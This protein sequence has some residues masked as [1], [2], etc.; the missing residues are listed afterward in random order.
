MTTS[1]LETAS[2]HGWHRHPGVRSGQQLTPGERAADALRN[3]MGSWAFV[4]LAMVFLAG[5][6]LFNRRQGFDP[7]PFILLNLVLSCLAAMQG[8]IL[9]IAARRS[10]HI[11]AEL[12]QHDFETDS[13]AAQMIEQ[14]QA[15]FE[16]LSRQ[17]QEILR[18]LAELNA[19]VASR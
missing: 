10:D 8:A 15:N 3:G 14:M 12:A 2:V 19:A 4:L 6:M 11:A 17:H 13:H 9:L 16:T 7:Y 5:W 18:Q 1:Q